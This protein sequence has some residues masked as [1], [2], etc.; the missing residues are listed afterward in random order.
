MV[1]TA[2]LAQPQILSGVVSDTKVVVTKPA[3]SPTV[4]LT[5]GG[6][7]QYVGF[8]YQ[9]PSGEQF[10]QSFY[11]PN[12]FPTFV[13]LQ[14]YLPSAVGGPLY[15]TSFN[16]YAEPGTWTLV[17]AYICSNIGFNCSAY[18]G[19][20]LK[21]LFKSLTVTVINH[22]APDIAP[23]TLKRGDIETETVSISHGPPLEIDIDGTDNVSGIAA[24]SACASLGNYGVCTSS[25][26]PLSR[27]RRGS[28]PSTTSFPQNAPIGTYTVT[29]VS[30]TDVAGNVVRVTDPIA[31]KAAFHGHITFQLTP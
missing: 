15:E 1:P 21:A 5:I 8:D 12:V 24:V 6:V 11:T 26:P 18:T 22:D 28:L 19:T 10:Y 3:A 14:G 9:G 23:P 4:A 29:F 27:I 31:L 30:L 13:K 25:P 7:A 20:Q 17:G 16:L 2:V